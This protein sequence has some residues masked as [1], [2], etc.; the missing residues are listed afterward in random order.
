MNFFSALLAPEKFRASCISCMI[1]FWKIAGKMSNTKKNKP[2]NKVGE[3][4][5][6]KYGPK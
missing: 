3:I 2:R 1:F 6:G 4:P 5:P